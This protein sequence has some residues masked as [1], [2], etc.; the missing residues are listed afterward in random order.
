[1]SSLQGYE[2]DEFGGVSERKAFTAT[3]RLEGL[4]QEKP[5][6]L[7]VLGPSKAIARFSVQANE[8]VYEITARLGIAERVASM[9]AGTHVAVRGNLVTH[10]W[11]TA[12]FTNRTLVELQASAIYE[13]ENG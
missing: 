5:V 13:I 2:V 1:M 3:F 9:R 4:L 10:K 6:A 12:G 7:H 8:N 11:Q